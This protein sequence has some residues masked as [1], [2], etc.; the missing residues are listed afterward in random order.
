MGKDNKVALEPQFQ[1]GR[2]M[3]G[4]G[5]DGVWS[6]SEVRGEESLTHIPPPLCS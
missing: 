5:L 4:E 6:G 3:G 2:S 1:T